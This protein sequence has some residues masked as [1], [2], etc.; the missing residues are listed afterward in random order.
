MSAAE[1]VRLHRLDWRFLLPK[2]PEPFNHLVLM[3]APAGAKERILESGLALRISTAIPSTRS[4]DAFI[5]LNNEPFD[6]VAASSSLLPG[7]AFYWEINQTSTKKIKTSPKKIARGLQQRGYHAVHTY[8]VRPT[9]SAAQFYFPLQ[10][11]GA[12]RW[13][14][15]NLYVGARPAQRLLE[16]NVRHLL[17][18]YPPL[19]S[20]FL[21]QI[22]IVAKAGPSDDATPSGQPDL[23]I[24]TSAFPDASLIPFVFTD[25]GNRLV[26]LPFRT[27]GT[28][29][30]G[31]LKVPKLPSFNQK[32]EA[33]QS[34]LTT[35]RARLT[36]AMRRTIP[37]PLGLIP[38]GDLL[39]SKES[40][41]TGQSL[42]RTSGSWG[43]PRAHKIHDLMS[44]AEWLACFHEEVQSER[45]P[46]GISHIAQWVEAPIETYRQRFGANEVEEKLFYLMRQR[47]QLLSG[48]RFF[49]V[50]QHRDFNV[51]NIFKD[52]G[53]IR[54]IDWE[55]GQSGPPLCDLLHF[56]THWNEV[57]R[58]LYSTATCLQAFQALFSPAPTVDPIT[59]AIYQAIDN[60]MAK[61]GLD[62][63]FYPLLLAYT[64]IELA[65]RRFDQQEAHSELSDDTRVNNEHVARFNLLAKEAG[66]L[67]VSNHFQGVDRELA[68]A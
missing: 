40:Y 6:I 1:H 21:S 18:I 4:A 31:I 56:V 50:W 45:Q 55:G 37:E 68:R 49:L 34:C 53:Q 44:A 7:S 10:A 42:L 33:E 62:R 63:R 52:E 57:A 60:Y 30:E 23:P 67:F 47:A 2:R 27:G 28:H 39:V 17:N 24:L 20:L 48:A 36:P 32:N 54:V 35:I 12:F 64:W 59:T 51:W 14:F 58:R 22:A 3:G 25:G 5:A 8:A 11:G 46:W 43:V 13:F 65:N 15:Q 38:F 26:M 29:P 61:L 41:L 19:L 16:W 66:A 9:F